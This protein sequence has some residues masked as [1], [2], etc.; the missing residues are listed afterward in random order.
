MSVIFL[1]YRH[2]G[3]SRTFILPFRQLGTVTY[4]DEVSRPLSRGHMGTRPTAIRSSNEDWQSAVARR[5]VSSSFFGDNNIS[6]VF[7][8]L[9]RL[10]GDAG[11]LDFGNKL[12]LDGV[13][14]SRA[15]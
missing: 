11:K 8:N 10:F 7:H 6:V 14:Y 4:V 15:P 9:R 1:G 3:R 5:M 12:A 2:T 13:Y